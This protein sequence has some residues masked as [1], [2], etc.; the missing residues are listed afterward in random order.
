MPS[1]QLQDAL[2]QA[3]ALAK[4]DEQVLDTFEIQNP[5]IA[6]ENRNL[7]LC[8][9]VDNSG[10]QQGD[11]D[12]VR[13]IVV[14]VAELLSDQFGTI[15]FAL[16]T[17][18][19]EDET[20]ILT[21]EFTDLTTISSLLETIVADGGGDSEENAFGAI[22]LAADSLN[23]RSGASTVRAMLLTTDE[24]SHERGAT[25]SEALAALQTEEIVFFYGFRSESVF[26]SFAI[27]TGGVQLDD[28]NSGTQTA[29]E[30][31]GEQMSEIL[32]DRREI[33]GVES[34]FLVNGFEDLEM[35]LETGDKQVFRAAAFRTAAPVRDEQGFADRELTIDN[36]NREVTDFLESVQTETA[37]VPIVHRSYLRSDLSAPQGAPF[38]L[39]L[40]SAAA[41]IYEVTGR[42]SFADV[43]NK[44][45]SARRFDRA[46]FPS[47]QA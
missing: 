22:K 12:L 6:R 11:I 26:E 47:L 42:L 34:I 14:E 16:A 32:L 13:E 21:P 18:R 44:P 46:R 3:Y 40:N 8:F 29:S 27:A 1:Q 9:V 30:I 17:F 15:R 45:A 24:P 25:E 38:R 28:N 35:T 31:A 43:V 7:D 5:A 4:V 23:W 10:S 37:Q 33:E 19:D 41:G 20:F 39:F 36:T 2:K